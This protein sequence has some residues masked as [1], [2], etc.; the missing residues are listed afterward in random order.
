MELKRA[1]IEDI[2]T[3][4]ALEKSLGKNK[5]Y[6]AY[7]DK[8][9]AL[10]E[11]KKATV[12]FITKD[13]EAVG[14]VAYEMKEDSHAYLSSILIKP[15]YQG[16][17][18]ARQ[19]MGKILEELKNVK[20]IDLVTHPENVRSISLCES[21]GFKKTERYENYFGDGEPRIKMVLDKSNL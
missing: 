14:H 11:L 13:G 15:E 21:F 10:E 17:G 1:T 7:T 5:L 12:Y 3:Y 9:E 6:S 2:D 19:A 16:Q 8:D 4:I 18:L 20:L